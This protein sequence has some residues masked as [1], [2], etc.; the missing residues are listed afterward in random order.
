MQ[1]TSRLG[2]FAGF[3]V[4]KGTRNIRWGLMAI[5]NVGTEVAELIVKER[6]TNGD[7]KDLPT[8]RLSKFA[9]V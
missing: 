7:F 9:C 6:K 5:K 2:F 1:F 8:F 4:V 3:A